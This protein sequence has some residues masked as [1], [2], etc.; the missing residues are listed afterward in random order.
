MKVLVLNADFQP[1]N[2]TTFQRGFNLVFKGKAE[3]LVSDE[4][5]TFS[6]FSKEF[7][8]PTVIRLLNFIYIPKRRVSLS[9]ENIFKR[10]GFSCVY[11]GSD[12]NLTLDHVIPKS[13]GGK[14]SWENLVTCCSKCNG[15]KDDRTPK[16]AGMNMRVK[17]HVP[18]MDSLFG[19]DRDELFDKIMEGNGYHLN[20]AIVVGLKYA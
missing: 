10:D 4:N 17:P 11:C 15:K 3:V 20:E 6:L 14:N 2:V 19:F 8:R 16:E 18:S 12:N 9:R 13:R 1:I 5:N 7:G